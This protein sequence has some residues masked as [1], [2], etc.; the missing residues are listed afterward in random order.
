[1][2]SFAFAVVLFTVSVY[3]HDEDDDD[4]HDEGQNQACFTTATNS[5]DEMCPHHYYCEF[6]SLTPNDDEIGKCHVCETTYD[7]AEHHY[8]DNSRPQCSTLCPRF[9]PSLFNETVKS[10]LRKGI[11]PKSGCF[12]PEDD[13]E[14]CGNIECKS[15]DEEGSCLALSITVMFE[16]IS[17]FFCRDCQTDDERKSA[18]EMAWLMCMHD[19]GFNATWAHNSLK[20]DEHGE[21]NCYVGGEG[22]V[23][24]EPGYPCSDAM[25]KCQ[26]EILDRNVT[27]SFS[28]QMTDAKCWG[29]DECISVMQDVFG[30]SVQVIEEVCDPPMDPLYY[31]LFAMLAMICICGTSHWIIYRRGHQDGQNQGGHNPPPGHI[32]LIPAGPGNGQPVVINHA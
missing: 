5:P 16:M 32:N 26:T 20:P 15:Q 23:T 6:K 3:G 19:H 7:G 9:R 2:K 1:M 21:M 28:Q 24:E 8:G 17:T 4:T 30:H 18:Y 25:T 12:I 14:E 31:P 22:K 27:L 10:G 11:I 29:K 13:K